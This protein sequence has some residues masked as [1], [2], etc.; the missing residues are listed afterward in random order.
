MKKISLAALVLTGCAIALPAAAQYGR[1]ERSQAEIALE[2]AKTTMA[3]QRAA[4]KDANVACAAKDYE[5]CVKAG[6]SYRKGT[7]GTQDY[8]LALKAYDRACKGKNGA[9][10]A[11]QAY[12]T[13]QGRGL[14]ADPVAARRLYK[15]S[16]DYDEVSG[17]A[18]Y[19]NMLF[20]GTG[21]AKNVPE[22][23]RLLR[24]SCDRG[25]EWA[26]GRLDELGGYD[27]NAAVYE[28]LNDMRGG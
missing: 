11:T 27:P 7:G 20:T 24:Q 14:D 1:V 17:C 6:D 12:L 10:C 4:R 25:Y 5:A 26:C 23:T 22:G 9:G 8:A 21:G 16:C 28:R 19:G 15:Q 3:D 13:L 2:N 18:G